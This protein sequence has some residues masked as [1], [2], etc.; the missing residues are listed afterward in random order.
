MIGETRATVLLLLILCILVAFPN[1]GTVIAEPKTI[2]VPDDFSTIQSAI[3]NAFGG[4]TIFVKKG[5]YNGPISETLIIDKPVSLIGEG[6]SLIGEST[7]LTLHPLLLNKT[8]FG[9]PYPT[10]NTSLIVKANNVSI[11]GFTIK[12][13]SVPSGGGGGISVIG[14]GTTISNC[15]INLLSLS[16]GGSYTTISETQ[17]FIATL[18]VK[19]SHQNISQT[20]IFNGDVDIDSSYINFVGNT[21][22]DE[23]SLNGSSNVISGNYFSRIVLEYSDLNRI[24]N[25][26]CGFICLGSYGHTCS[27]NTISA[28]ILDGDNIWGIL[29]ADGSY[30]VFYDNYITNY[31]GS[32]DGYGVAFGG[33]HLVA[34]NNIFYHNTFLNNNKNVGYNWQIN[35]IGNS[36]DNGIEGNYWDDYNGTD[37]DGDGIGDTPYIIDEKNQDNFPLIAPISTF[38]AGTWEYTE[39]LVD[40]VSNSTV[41]DFSFDHEFTMVRFDVEGEDETTGFCRVTLPKDLLYAEGDWTVLVDGASVSPTLSEDINNTYIYFTYSHSTKTVEIIGTE[42]IPEFPSWIPML[43]TLVAVVVII[44]VYKNK[45]KKHK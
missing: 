11:S 15:I 9:Q 43:F 28:N 16:L 13:P 20:T 7:T 8:I 6:T 27:N 24:H 1:V 33:N 3:D 34:E 29:M 35:G 45:L 26:T 18:R 42:A 19:G 32:H 23:I 22:I 4:D 39:Y 14:D 37:A 5:N 12:T 41:S 21:M 38:D 44:F 10:Y 31:T 30:N 40:I 2:V 36:W 17:L 25:N